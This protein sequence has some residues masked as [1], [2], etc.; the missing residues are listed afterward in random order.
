MPRLSGKYLELLKHPATVGA[1][2]AGASLAGNALGVDNE[3]KG[4]GR[5]ALE[6]LGAGLGAAGLSHVS[7]PIIK[8]Q[9]LARVLIGGPTAFAGLVGAPAGNLVGGGVSNVA[10]AIGIPGFQ[11]YPVLD[12]EAYG[13][14]N[15]PYG[16]Y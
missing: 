8:E 4:A 9:P 2:A 12:P 13:S 15:Y 11:H 6:A 14:S 1:I 5:I 7:R 3:Q 16:T 10:N